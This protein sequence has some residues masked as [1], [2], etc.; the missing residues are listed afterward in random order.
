MPNDPLRPLAAQVHLR[1]IAT[2][3]IH[4]HLWPWDYFAD[5]P[6]DTAGLARTAALIAAARGEVANA[7]VVDNGDVLQGNPLGDLYGAP[8]GLAPGE[9]HPM[10]AALATA[11]IEVSTLGNHE[12][13]YGL[14]LLGRVLADAPYPVVCANVVHAPARDPATDATLAQPFVILDRQVTDGAGRAH[15][16]RIGVIGFVPPQI[17]AWDRA[18]LTGRVAVH[19]IVAAAAARVPQLRAAGADLVVALAHTGF[20][21][22]APQP[23]M[24]NAATA[25]AGVPGIDVIVAGHTHRTFPA[26]DA[27]GQP[28]LDPV[29]GT[30]GGRPA[31][32]PGFWGSHVGVVDLLLSPGG[33]WRIEA[34]QSHLRPIFTVEATGA[35]VP[36]VGD[37]PGVLAVS[38]AAHEAT[39]RSIRR[40]IGALSAPLTSYFALAGDDPAVRLVAAVQRARMAHLLEGRPEAELPMLSA[41]G[42]FK[43]GGRGGPGFFTDVP[44]GPLSMKHAA[45]LYIYPNTLCALRVTGAD[46]R[47]WLE[48]AARLYLPVRPGGRDQPLIDPTFPSFTF[49]TIDGLTYRFDLAAPPGARV[50]ALAHRGKPVAPADRFMIVCNNYRAGG[51]LPGARPDRIVIEDAEPVRD[52]LIRHIQQVG[53]LVPPAADGWGFVPMPG[54]TVTF[55]TGPAAA[56]HLSAAPLPSEVMGTTPAG[57]L[58]LRLAL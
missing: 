53:T 21:P 26:P 52:L 30:A 2:T 29:A 31:V 19:D 13:N 10:I 43:T 40:P 8:G 15:R 55:D 42:P 45:D 46:L 18:A 56:G 27:A 58:R 11:G 25:L 7:L 49:D 24:E 12:F 4:A 51:S 23:G 34:A 5:R 44:A 39:L 47:D 48:H 57:F 20:G 35:I 1:L 3:D 16:L 22:A 14:D 32:M 9:R 6:T 37:H 28:G 54:T 36:A 38:R 33:G 50:T 41:A 17:L